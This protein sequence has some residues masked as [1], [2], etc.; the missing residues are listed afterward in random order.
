MKNFLVR[1]VLN[2]VVRVTAPDKESAIQQATD[3]SLLDEIRF[4][5]KEHPSEFIIELQGGDLIP[6]Q[7]LRQARDVRAE[8]PVADVQ[9]PLEIAKEEEDRGGD[10]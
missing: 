7:L 4:V 6:S 8:D 3:Q 1:A 2:K 10:Q 9:E 5:A